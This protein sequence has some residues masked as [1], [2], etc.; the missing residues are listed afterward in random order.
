MAEMVIFRLIHG[1]AP[2]QCL[3]LEWQQLD[4]TGR[5]MDTSDENKSG[6]AIGVALND[7]TGH[8]EA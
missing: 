8:M 2:A 6:K 7:D 3:D 1:I 4:L 5:T